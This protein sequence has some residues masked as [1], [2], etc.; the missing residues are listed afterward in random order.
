MF[1]RIFSAFLIIGLL[2]ISAFSQESPDSIPA[3]SGF[4]ISLELKEASD[5]ISEYEGYWSENKDEAIDSSSYKNLQELLSTVMTNSSS[6]KDTSV[7]MWQLERWQENVNS[8]LQLSNVISGSL[9]ALNDSLKGYKNKLEIETHQW[10]VEALQMATDSTT[11]FVWND[12]IQKTQDELKSTLNQIES[13]ISRLT[14]EENLRYEEYDQLTELNQQLT[15]IRKSDAHKIVRNDLPPIWKEGSRLVSTEQAVGGWI[16]WYHELRIFAEYYPNYFLSFSLYLLFFWT[17]LHFANR[18]RKNHRWLDQT[19]RFRI[20]K[21]W[22]RNPFVSAILLTLFVN[23][24]FF[25]EGIEEYLTRPLIMRRVEILLV[26]SSFMIIAW[27]T[28]VKRLRILLLFPLILFVVDGTILTSLGLSFG[29]RILFILQ[30]LIATALC[31]YGLRIYNS[32]PSTKKSKLKTQVFVFGTLVT[33]GFFGSAVA[34]TVGAI[35]FSRVLFGASLFALAA[36]F[37]IIYISLSFPVMLHA[38]VVSP[39]G[40]KN[41]MIHELL[42]R[43]MKAISWIFQV[44]IFT[45]YCLGLLRYVT[46]GDEAVDILQT[47]W[48]YSFAIGQLQFSVGSILDVIV[49]VLI[50]YFLSQLIFILVRDEI[51]V[52]FTKKKGLPLAYGMISKYLMLLIGFVAAASVLGIDMD[53]L[54]FVV[55]ALGVG[56][57]FGLQALVGNFIAGIVILFE[58]PMRVGDVIRVGTQEGI[59]KE[60]GA[61]AVRMRLW[62][63]AEVLI[64]NYDIVTKNVLNWTLNDS[65]RRLEAILYVVPEAPVEEVLDIIHNSA[66]QVNINRDGPETIVQYKGVEG[67]AAVFK[68]LYWIS[69]ENILAADS[70]MYMKAYDALNEK[71]WIM[72]ASRVEIDKGK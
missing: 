48:G 63:G 72:K 15:E 69:I 3:P 70:D 56:I 14:L 52:R 46:L 65:L 50:T 17:L 64:P 18:Y 21:S 51:A 60:I 5:V 25:I 26:Y 67:S 31:I 55:G 30:Y 58:R 6:L 36:G 22:I 7:S 35:S 27:G 24:I 40:K 71:G 2:P 9:T 12:Q 54:G 41:A 66:E 19:Q 38:L 39:Y 20:L 13:D 37:L 44:Y 16:I 53:K 57:G 61:R 29:G 23:R 8:A 11:L 68:C 28:V 62:D 1:Y 47:V 43:N 49:I 59:V 10:N 4:N 45:I 32:M 33:V 34:T 42:S